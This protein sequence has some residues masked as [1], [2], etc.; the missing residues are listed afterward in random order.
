M[1]VFKV[2][3][4]PEGGLTFY[5]ESTNSEREFMRVTELVA[6]DEKMAAKQV[7]AMLWAIH[8]D[9]GEPLYEVVE[10]EVLGE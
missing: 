6:E 7:E 9:T 4:K 1:P 3:S 2:A 10:I 5:D 8:V